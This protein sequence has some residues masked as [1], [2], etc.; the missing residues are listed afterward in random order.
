MRC[1]VASLYHVSTHA[2][3]KGCY[4]SSL[5]TFLRRR[6]ETELWS[7]HV[8]GEDNMEA[9]HADSDWHVCSVGLSSTCTATWAG[10]VWT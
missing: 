8:L 9:A 6:G 3:R 10:D 1:A 5:M 7:Y 2:V 4:V